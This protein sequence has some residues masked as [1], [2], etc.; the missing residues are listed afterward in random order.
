[1]IGKLH[2]IAIAFA[3]SMTGFAANAAETATAP[4]SDSCGIPDYPVTWIDDGL[5]GTVRLALLV[6]AD[7]SV[8]DKKVVATSGYRELDKASL[9]AGGTCKFGAAAKDSGRAPGW[10]TVQYTWI[11][12]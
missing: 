12:N 3:L 11:A 10:T 5:Q 4:T 2:A 7:G 1:M 9:R 6:G 8:K